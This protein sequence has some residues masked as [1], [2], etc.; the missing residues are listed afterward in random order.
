MHLRGGDAVSASGTGPAPFCRPGKPLNR[1]Q[2]RAE[3]G[4][5]TLAASLSLRLG[6]DSTRSCPN[7]RCPILS[8]FVVERAGDPSGPPPRGPRPPGSP[9]T[10]S[11]S[12]GW[13]K[14][15]LGRGGYST[16]ARP[17]VP[18]P[19]ARLCAN[20]W[21]TATAHHPG[22]PVQALLG[23]GQDLNS[24]RTRVPHPR[25][26]F[27]FAARVGRHEPQPTSLPHPSRSEGWETTNVRAR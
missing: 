22:C 1:L 3:P 20:G 25:R 21:E 11:S 26:V 17:S 8:T 14:A 23:R 12:L 9:R 13:I 18:H 5:P 19:F 10:R 7:P 24:P 6:W 2:L 4:C 27:V 15:L 16:S